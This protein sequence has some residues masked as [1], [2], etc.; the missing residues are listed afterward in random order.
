MAPEDSREASALA[1]AKEF[2]LQELSDGPQ[3]SKHI[4]E[5]LKGLGFSLS[6]VRRAQQQLR[7]SPYKDGERWIWKLP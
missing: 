5:A 2:L 1:E 6:S 3:P 7:I 4:T